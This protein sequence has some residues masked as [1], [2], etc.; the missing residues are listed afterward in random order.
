MFFVRHPV[1]PPNLLKTD[2]I[3]K[4][5]M[6]KQSKQYSLIYLNLESF[7][8]RPLI[9]DY[10]SKIQL[11]PDEDDSEPLDEEGIRWVKMVVGAL[12]HCGRAVNNKILTALSTIGSPDCAMAK[13]THHLYTPPMSLD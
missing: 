10:G 6:F 5:Q 1:C 2:T 8:W 12:L 11:A 3:V 13:R 4:S 7:L 9:I